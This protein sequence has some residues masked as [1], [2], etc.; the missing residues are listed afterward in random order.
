MKIFKK[1]FENFTLQNNY[2]NDQIVKKISHFYHRSTALIR[3]ELL[4]PYRIVFTFM[5]Q[6]N[7][8]N[9]AK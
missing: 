5:N 8:Y 7:K 9:I 2:D 3:H 1:G 6:L 4:L